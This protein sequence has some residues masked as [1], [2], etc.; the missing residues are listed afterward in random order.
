MKADELD[1]DPFASLLAD[2]E[3]ELAAGLG[4]NSTARFAHLADTQLAVRLVN[5][6]QCLELLNAVWPRADAD[7]NETVPESV[8][9]FQIVR[10]LG[11]GGFG[12]VYLAFDPL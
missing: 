11:R 8:G 9:R 10:E 3:A 1:D 4:G 7:G 6:G 12:I 5:A 2:Y